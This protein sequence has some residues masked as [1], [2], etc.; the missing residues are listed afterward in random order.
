MLNDYGEQGTITA[1]I[2]AISCERETEPLSETTQDLAQQI[3]KYLKPILRANTELRVRNT[4]F[5]K[6]C[7][8]LSEAYKKVEAIAAKTALY[9]KELEESRKE[10]NELH[11]EVANKELIQALSL[12]VPTTLTSTQVSSPGRSWASVVSQSSFASSNT[13]AAR[14]GPDW[15]SQL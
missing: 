8:R 10:V 2:K 5:A 12:G 11:K 3:L 15:T 6:E 1:T 13:R 7:R 4:E 14:T 9:R